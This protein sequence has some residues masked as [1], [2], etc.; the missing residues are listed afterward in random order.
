VKNDMRGSEELSDGGANWKNAPSF[1]Y[2]ILYGQPK[3]LFG[4]TE[5]HGQKMWKDIFVD[6]HIPTEALDE[7][8]RIREIELR[9]SCEGSG[10]ERPTFLIFRLRGEENIEK[11]RA[12]VEGMNAFESVRCGA[13]KGNMGFYRIGVTTPLWY[14]KDEEE[15]VH[16]WLELPLKVHIV[17]A[18]IKVLSRN[19][20]DA[21]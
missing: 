1:I 14:R 19:Q 4:R 13:E 2:E 3:F 12:L 5:S 7:L 8:D 15:F 17:L 18:T 9:A 16:W 11:I 6:E 20:A 21:L 10:P